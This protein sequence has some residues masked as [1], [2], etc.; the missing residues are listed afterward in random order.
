[1][2]IAYGTDS[3]VYPHGQNGRQFAYMVRYGMTPMQAIQSATIRAAE[4]LGKDDALGSIAPGRFAD[5]V[6]V[7]GDPL[8]NIRILEN[9]AHVMQ[10]G[11]TVR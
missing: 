8:T 3:G 1:V 11:K 2:N 4:L 5:L 10:G 9:V 6:A 7:D